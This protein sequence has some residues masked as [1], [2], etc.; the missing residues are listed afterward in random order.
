[1]RVLGLQTSHLF[2]ICTNLGYGTVLTAA[3][4]RQGCSASGL[5]FSIQ[6][7]TQYQFP[8]LTAVL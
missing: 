8:E 7:D 6:C 1:M 2:L 5:D 3:C 4:A